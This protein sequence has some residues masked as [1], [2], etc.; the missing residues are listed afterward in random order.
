[1]ILLPEAYFSQ[2]CYINSQLKVMLNHKTDSCIDN[3]NF[4]PCEWR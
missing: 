4:G 3:Q 2:N 1:M